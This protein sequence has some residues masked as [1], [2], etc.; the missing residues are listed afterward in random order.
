MTRTPP[1]ARR[2]GIVL[3]VVI[4]LLTLFAVV[5][6]TFVIYSQAEAASSRAWRESE[7][8]Q[9]PDL[10]PEM[11]LAYFLGQLVYDTD[12]TN[13]AL[14]GHSL[15]RTMYGKAGNSIPFNGAGR[16]HTD[17]NPANDDFYKIDYTNYTGGAARDPDQSGSPNVPY[18][19]PDY[20][21]LFLS[22]VRASDGAVLIPSYFRANPQQGQG[23]IT[24]RPNATYHPQFPV[25]EDAG[26]DVKN[27]ADSPGTL[28]GGNL[29]NNDSVWLD[30]GFPVMKAADGRKFKPLFA[31]LIQD[32]DN[33]V[34][35]NVHGNKFGT[36]DTQ[37][38]GGLGDRGTFWSTSEHGWG[39][40][41]VN[42]AKVL[43]G[44]DSPG[45]PEWQAEW[46]Y[47]LL[48]KNGVQGR[49]DSQAWFYAV[50]W[51]VLPPQEFWIKGKFYSMTDANCHICGQ[52]NLS[53]PGS[54][55]FAWFPQGGNWYRTPGS[56]PDCPFPSAHLDYGRDNFTGGD[57]TPYPTFYNFFD[58]SGWNAFEAGARDRCFPISS[59][60][61]LLRYNDRGSPALT[62]DL[63]RL[64]PQSFGD[65]TLGPPAR[66]LVTTHAFDVDRPGVVPCIWDPAQQPY[67]LAGN[68][69][70]PTG[71]PVP[72]PAAPLAAPPANS[73]FSATGQALTAALGRIDLNRKLP[74]YPGAD[75]G[76]MQIPNGSYAQFQTAQQARQD[77]AQEI[78][79]CLRK[80]TGAGDPN[81]A[82]LP[83]DQKNALRWLAQ[84]SVN[85]VDFVDSDDYITPFAW[86][87]PDPNSRGSWQWVYG[88]ELPRL[89]VNEVYAEIGND[90]SDPLNGAQATKPY[91]V[92]F[93]VELHNPFRS[94][95]FGNL[96]EGGAARLQTPGGDAV[97]QLVV[98]G[99]P[100]NNLRSASNVLGDPDAANIKTVVSKWEPEPAPAAQPTLAATEYVLVRSF[101]SISDGQTQGTDGSNRGFA[102]VGPKDDFPGQGG[103][104]PTLRVKDQQ[105][106]GNRSSLVYE[107]PLSTDMTA[108]PKHTLLLR[109]L[110]CPTM[111]PQSDPNQ[112]NYNPYVTV[113]YAEDVPTND[114]VANDAN[115]MHNPTAV[116][117]RFAVG[118]NQPY[119]ADK[120][121][122]NS[123]SDQAN[124]LQNQPQHTFF[125]INYQHVTPFDWLFFL[126]RPTHNPMELLQ[127]SGFKPH[128]LTQQF[129]TGGIDPQTSQPRNKHTHR[130]AWYDEKARIYRLFEFLRG[131]HRI[132]G[133]PLGGRTLGKI[134]I[135]TIWDP[136][137]FRALC[138]R[139]PSDFF[140]DTDVDNAFTALV[141][142]RTP[143]GTPGT[144]DR[145][146]RGMAS[147]CSP[148]GQQYAS[149][150]GIDD[151]FLRSAGDAN[152]PNRRLFEVA[153]LPG[154]ANGHP[155]CKSQMMPKIFG[156]TTTRSNVFAVWV[157][158]GFFEVLDDSNAY[159]P[160]V[161]GKELGRAENR[162]V[163]HRMF[164]VV[165]RS[166]LTFD[167]AAPTKAGARP[168]FMDVRSAVTTAP[169]AATI[170]LTAVTG[171]YEELRFAIQQGDKLTIDAGP[172]QETITVQN[173]NVA[174]NQITAN[175]TKNH[176]SVGVGITNVGGGT[177]MGNP[178][179]Q[180]QFDP[181]NPLYSGVVR[182]ISI[183]E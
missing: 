32:L 94:D 135:N 38:G 1:E 173:V 172:R 30:L 178:G 110:A 63:F 25:M 74:D 27:L 64:C 76:T 71:D 29:A 133:V 152:D 106:N 123:Q 19:Y 56:S 155:F 10:D 140:S 65:P 92:K 107:A 170:T 116:A 141:Q 119:A 104:T 14:R 49:C 129:M 145:P 175:F 20:N 125:K 157:T 81:D 39:P 18:T 176:Q 66:R 21:N 108:L 54:P 111:P 57:E 183:I 87:K 53:L 47:L 150:S 50:R 89:V 46:R 100:N 179:P 79:D 169:A 120:S 126:D 99:Q 144:N 22:A 115:G 160:P 181:R 162:H 31:P 103:P 80:V 44:L 171:N 26:G 139:R 33:R 97:Y 165:D 36:W 69:L 7:T 151:T 23:P 153:N 12:N 174:A 40:W 85:I 43:K 28:I 90:A 62:S 136:E 35:V 70:Y 58:P 95:I 149:G 117:Q 154:Y 156:N 88:T 143:T 180:S 52:G 78:F 147:A 68:S 82:S 34:N 86:S 158:V 131:G 121:Q 60:E 96:S 132:Q 166:N 105:A 91:K 67:T 84:L 161:L 11:L 148:A 182:H 13:S 83:A 113:D 127:V 177:T 45:A 134:N 137:T 93:W 102:L 75:G 17:P 122:Q 163:R 98:A 15:G 142:S 109:R 114:A 77:F 138:D 48:G 59:M 167:P 101:H 168:F 61:A 146:F 37:R 24:L 2:S 41:E 164:A 16:L 3:L 9:R 6:I 159:K 55:Q 42:P 112:D 73:E 4:T 124:Q 130:A 51:P 128:E 8:L 5:G 72:F 118:R